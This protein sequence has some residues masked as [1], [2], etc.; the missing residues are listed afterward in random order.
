MYAVRGNDD[1]VKRVSE[2]AGKSLSRDYGDEFEDIDDLIDRY[3]NAHTEST[4]GSNSIGGGE[5]VCPSKQ[6]RKTRDVLSTTR[7]I[8][9][10]SSKE[11]ILTTPVAAAAAANYYAP[12]SSQTNSKFFV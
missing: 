12:P 10:V 6:R 5:G 2:A 7:V 9:R 8:K 4:G 3:L 1:E 11:I